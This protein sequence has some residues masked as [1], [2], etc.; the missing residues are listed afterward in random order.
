MAETLGPE[1]P[2]SSAWQ[3]SAGIEG[4]GLFLLWLPSPPSSA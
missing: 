3:C 1:A 2:A 4:G